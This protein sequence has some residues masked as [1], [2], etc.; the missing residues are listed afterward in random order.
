MSILQHPWWRL[1]RVGN[2]LYL[3]ILLFL[4]RYCIFVPL[5]NR[6]DTSPQLSFTGFV[7]LVLSIIAAAAAGYVLN[8]V[9]DVETDKINKPHRVSIGESITAATALNAGMVLNIS[10]IVLGFAAA[11]LAGN[12]MLG[13]IQVICVL[14]L[15]QYARSW[16][17]TALWGNIVVAFLAALAVLMPALYE[18][19]IFYTLKD[20]VMAWVLGILGYNSSIAQSPEAY[21]TGLAPT[22]LA[23]ILP[24]SAFA[25]LLSLVREIVK[26]AEDEEGDRKAQYKTLPI[27]GGIWLNKLAALI[28]LLLCVQLIVQ[29][30]IKQLIYSDL[31]AAV[32]AILLVLLPLLWYIWRLWQATYKTDFSLL[33]RAAK[34]I[35]AIG[36]CYLPYLATRLQSMTIV[37]A[38]TITL[39]EGQLPENINISDVKIDTIIRIGDANPDSTATE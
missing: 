32:A 23:Y 9:E 8:D 24:Y 2:L 37:P 6:L 13:W 12:Y 18:Q 10:A 21:I 14:V 38:N 25:F 34:I 20:Q 30:I 3:G 36:L 39:D 17:K 29:F 16:K 4:L 22:I 11:Y 33:S 5:F 26:D 27:V 1:L 35:M 7:L 19:E 28:P 31:T 15:W